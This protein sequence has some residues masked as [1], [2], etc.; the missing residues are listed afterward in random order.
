MSAYVIRR[1]LS[2]V[3][4]TIG[5]M[6]ITFFVFRVVGGNPA[7]RIAGKNATPARIAQISHERGYDKPLFLN[8]RQFPTQLLDA[9]FPQLCSNLLRLDFGRSFVT[10]QRVSTMLREGV[11]PSLCVTTPLFF[12]ELFLGVGLALLAAYYRNTWI[13]RS[14]VLLSVMG[15]SISSLV[16]IMLAQY[17]LA[18]V[19]R[20]F[21]VWGFESPRYLILP[22]LVGV[23]AGVGGELR[24]YRTVML[25]E[26][27]QDYVRTARAKGVSSR[28]ILFHHVLRNALIPILTN[29]IIAIPFLYTGALLLE[30]FFGIPGLGRLTVMALFNFDD[31]VVFATTFIGSIMFVLF[32][33]LTDIA[34]TWADPRIRLK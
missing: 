27:Y 29:V 33:A 19:W 32:N 25:D 6:L 23:I 11:G 30:N 21:P 22:V 28:G 34:Y 8:F 1:L 12:I 10:K 13:D 14:L 15:M 2:V 18:S 16:Y 4:I 24:F 26:M 5:V 31:D 17:W 7:Y 20:L 9:Q 3:P